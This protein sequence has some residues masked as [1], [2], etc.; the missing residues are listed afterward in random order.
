MIASRPVL[1]L[2]DLVDEVSNEGVTSPAI[3]GLRVLQDRPRAQAWLSGQWAG[4]RPVT[5]ELWPSLSCNARCP[6]CPYRRSGA[7]D[8][9]DEQDV[10][11]V[12]SSGLAA[13]LPAELAAAGVRSV[14]LTGGGEP[15]LSPS[16]PLLVRR[17][18][19]AG[20]AWGLF[21]N[22]ALLDVP[23]AA[24]LARHGPRW[25]RV[26]LDAGTAR[27]HRAIY[28]PGIDFEDVVENLVAVGRAWPTLSTGQLGVSFAVPWWFDEARLRD[29]AQLVRQVVEET[30]GGLS[31]VAIRPRAAQFR[32]DDDGSPIANVPV[33]H[34]DDL[35]RLGTLARRV[36]DDVLG[37]DPRV[38]VD[39]KE[40]LF[41]AARLDP[42]PFSG[43]GIGWMTVV[44]E[45][46]TGYA[47][48]ELAGEAHA[49]GSVADGFATAWDSAARV[50]L[51]QDVMDGIIG[52]PSLHRVTPL[53]AFLGRARAAMDGAWLTA[54]DATA[55]LDAVEARSFYRT[56]RPEFV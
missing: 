8:Q 19:A 16:L 3:D 44:A 30:G 38:R 7:R 4:L 15:L 51:T 22:G 40:S 37:D 21:T 12:L 50:R 47:I 27:D 56:S 45:D 34:S 39:V 49:W 29:G 46:G 52:L 11:M 10:P 31:S 41:Q 1:A 48:S 24:G 28:G 5:V 33:P 2:L 53:D 55:F 6:S 25:V 42:P 35:A 9:A 23:T 43:A 32:R 18:A 26:S 13:R 54:D 14:M 36:F 20:L 17:L